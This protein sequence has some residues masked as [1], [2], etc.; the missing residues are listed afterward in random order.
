V[1]LAKRDDIPAAVSG[2]VFLDMSSH[3]GLLITTYY[4]AVGGKRLST[5]VFPM[6]EPAIAFAGSGTGAVNVFHFHGFLLGHFD[7]NP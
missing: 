7:P 1:R 4:R 3:F 6:V 5:E 2:T